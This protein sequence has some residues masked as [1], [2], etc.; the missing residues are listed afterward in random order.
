VFH[1]PVAFKMSSIILPALAGILT[2]FVS[3]FV[4]SRLSFGPALI[5][6]GGLIP[7]KMYGQIAWSVADVILMWYLA[8]SL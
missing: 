3:G 6:L 8:D 4:Y 5:T 2:Y 7:N 1:I